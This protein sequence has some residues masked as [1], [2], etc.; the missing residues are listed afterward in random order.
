[1]IGFPPKSECQIQI[2][3]RIHQSDEACHILHIFATMSTP[4]QSNGSQE[5]NC[6]DALLQ[7]SLE[8]KATRRGVY[9][10]SN[11][12]PSTAKKPIGALKTSHQNAKD[13]SLLKKVINIREGKA[14]LIDIQR[15]FRG[16]Q[17]WSNAY[18]VR[19]QLESSNQTRQLAAV[20][21]Q[22]AWR[23]YDQKM[24]YWFATLRIQKVSRGYIVREQLEREHAAATKIQSVLRGQIASTAY[25]QYFAAMS[26]QAAW[27]G[28][29]AQIVYMVHQAEIMAATI[30]QSAWRRHDCQDDYLLTLND[31]YIVQSVARRFLARKKVAAVRQEKAALEVQRSYEVKSRDDDL[32]FQLEETRKQLDEEK[33]H[34]NDLVFKL[35]ETRKQLESMT[36]FKAE[37]ESM[38]DNYDMRLRHAMED[39]EKLWAKVEFLTSK[40]SAD[41][42]NTIMNTRNDVL[43]FQLQAMNTLK[44]AL[45]STCECYK[46]TRDSYKT[47]LRHAMEDKEK[48]RSQLEEKESTVRELMAT[49]EFLTSKHTSADKENTHHEIKSPHD[50]E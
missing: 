23:G 19:V 39:K 20:D 36:T 12:K 17:G 33:T 29:F 27:R 16:S 3:K 28:K 49:V 35:R 24:R 2:T 4:R 21:I 31:I 7:Q 42:E 48:L 6:D 30:I 13:H 44:A 18:A 8:T 41:K 11:K 43:V 37:L 9:F 14:A 38:C 5:R 40:H 10:T 45:Q 26:I 47:R 22:R 34:N 15:S 25:K 50:G 1:L 46:L 32:V